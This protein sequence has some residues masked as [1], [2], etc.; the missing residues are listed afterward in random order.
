MARV[1]LAN[2]LFMLLK[3]FLATI[4]QVIK[5]VNASVLRVLPVLHV[6]AGVTGKAGLSRILQ[7]SGKPVHSRK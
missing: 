6:G 4:L 1:L 7:K 2:L 5:Q 3:S